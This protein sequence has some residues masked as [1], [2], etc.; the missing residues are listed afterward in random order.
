MRANDVSLEGMR[1]RPVIDNA[2]VELGSVEDVTFD[3]QG[4][5]VTSLVVRMGR[6]AADRLHVKRPT[7]GSAR[8]EVS[9][10]RIGSIGDAVLLNVNE[11]EMA[12][13]LYTDPAGPSS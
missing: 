5:R 1:G 9:T 11:R 3:P 8:I 4:F 10:E 2:G 13:M 7:L 6:E 12:S